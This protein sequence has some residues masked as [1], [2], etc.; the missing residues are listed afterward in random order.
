MFVFFLLVHKAL[1]PTNLLIYKKSQ[2]IFFPE[3]VV[4]YIE[5]TE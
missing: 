2:T 3:V 4:L 5:L 1:T